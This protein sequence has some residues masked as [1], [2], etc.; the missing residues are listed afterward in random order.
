MTINN[1]CEF[2][3]NNVSYIQDGIANQISCSCNLNNMRMEY[4]HIL[5]TTLLHY[6][7]IINESQIFS[8][9]LVCYW[10]SIFT[11]LMLLMI[12]MFQR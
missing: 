7:I 5:N 8:L 11:L 1:D 12:H 3:D 9:S 10:L 6:W 4:F 2:D